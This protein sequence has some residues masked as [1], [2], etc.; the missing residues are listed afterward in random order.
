MMPMMQGHSTAAAAVEAAVDAAGDAAAVSAAHAAGRSGGV[1]PERCY[2][3]SCGMYRQNHW[4][5]GCYH[6]PAV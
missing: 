3:V 4:F 5:P 2:G 1:G 6:Y